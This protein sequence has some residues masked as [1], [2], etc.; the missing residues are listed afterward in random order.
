[1][2]KPLAVVLSVYQKERLSAYSHSS[3]DSVPLQL[4]KILQWECRSGD[5]SWS[6]WN[7]PI[8]SMELEFY[9]IFIS[10]IFKNSFLKESHY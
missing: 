5:S 6:R 9:E 2:L 3:V 1:M 8:D 7:P 4:G 10:F